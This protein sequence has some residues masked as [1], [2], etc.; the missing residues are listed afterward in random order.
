MDNHGIGLFHLIGIH[1]PLRSDNYILRGLFCEF[2]EGPFSN[3]T[4]SYGPLVAILINFVGYFLLKSRFQRGQATFPESIS[5][6]PREFD[7]PNWG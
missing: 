1:P 4:G 3:L 5:I 6:D 2:L 7:C